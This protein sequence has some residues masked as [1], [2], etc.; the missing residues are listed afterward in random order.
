MEE[1]RFVGLDLAVS[2]VQFA[3]YG[4]AGSKLFTYTLNSALGD[5]TDEAF[6]LLASQLREVRSRLASGELREGQEIRIG[7]DGQIQ[8]T[9]GAP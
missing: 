6:L 5:L 7:P 8:V 4:E 1:T 3:V 9:E 2:S